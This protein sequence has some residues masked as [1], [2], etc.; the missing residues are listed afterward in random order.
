MPYRA[1]G[2]VQNRISHSLPL[3]HSRGNSDVSEHSMHPSPAEVGLT[4]SGSALP[5]RLTL[6]SAQ[7]SSGEGG[8]LLESAGPLNDFLILGKVQFLLDIF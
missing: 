3:I 7:M 1:P 5:P 2:T 6:V 4:L 8:F